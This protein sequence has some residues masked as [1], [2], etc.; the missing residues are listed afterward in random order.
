MSCPPEIENVVRQRRWDGRPA[1][2]V[3]VIALLLGLSQHALAVERTC[4]GDAVANTASVLC[5][6]P[7]GPCT[8]TEV[9][10][11][12]NIEVP[13]G[14]CTFDLGGRS[15]RVTKTFQMI[16]SGFIV[17]DNATDITITSTGKLKA[18]GDFVR[19]DGQII[20]G[21][22][23]DLRSLGRIEVGGHLDVNGDGAGNVR[24]RARGDVSILTTAVIQGIGTSTTNDDGDRYAD[25]GSLEAISEAGSI[26]WAAATTF[27]GQNHGQGGTVV[28]QAAERINLSQTIDASG[29]GGG[30]GDVQ[31][32][33]GDDISTIRNIDVT[34]RSGGG[35]GGNITLAAGADDL[36]GIKPG[37]DVVVDG[38]V[39]NLEGSSDGVGETGEGDGGYA[40]ISAQGAV[41][42]IGTGVAIR[43]GAGPLSAGDGGTVDISASAGDLVLEAPIFAKGGSQ[44]GRGGYAGISAS[45]D[46]TV[47]AA[48]DLSARRA[49]G[50]CHVAAGRHATVDGTITADGLAADATAGSIEV[51]GGLVLL[52]AVT[53]ARNLKATGDHGHE[54]ML[55][56]CSVTVDDGVSVDGRGG[57]TVPGA[58]VGII[59]R[60]SIQIRP[61]AQILAGSTGGITLSHPVGVQPVTNGASLEP[62]PTDSIEGSFPACGAE[63]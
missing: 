54:I 43:A 56:G 46:V 53:I 50:R 58:R 4:S 19:I 9:T 55:R 37:G 7:S 6:A 21:G 34:S 31:L 47:D 36:G 35:A 59:G 51:H 2:V 18:R 38:A 1:A 26:H 25:G 48:I 57:S 30:G 3:W 45:N 63:S 14:G 28:L 12:G 8:A 33:A 27:R 15:L 17:V 22:D 40:T 32:R 42:F 23:I 16:G 60:D 24:L 13:S 5:A 41:Q 52:G 20:Q 11:G 10:L 62:S 39:L 61:N 44:G 49:G 29:G